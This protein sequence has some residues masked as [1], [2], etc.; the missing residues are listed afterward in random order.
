MNELYGH[1]IFT[2]ENIMEWLPSSSDLNPIENL[3]SVVKMKLYE[4]EKQYS[5]KADQSEAIKWTL[6]IIETAKVKKIAYSMDN[7]GYLNIHKSHVTANISSNNNVVF[8][9][10][11]DMKIVYYNN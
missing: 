6:P 3:W 4:D 1:E 10:A 9:L 7:T 2:G 11:S 5:S 8:F